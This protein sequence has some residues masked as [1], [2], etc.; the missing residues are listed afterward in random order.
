MQNSNKKER[1]I[2]RDDG[3]LFLLVYFPHNR[4]ALFKETKKKNETFQWVLFLGVD[5]K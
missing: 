4:V 3:V 2:V 5:D 1:S